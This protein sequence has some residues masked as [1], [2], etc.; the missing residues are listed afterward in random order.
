MT[1]SNLF[2]DLDNTLWAFSV[3]ADST[4]RE[5]YALNRLDRYF[6]SYDQFFAIYQKENLRLWGLYEKGEITK[7]ELNYRRFRH[8]L[9]VV[10]VGDLS[11]AD[12]YG[13]DFFRIIRTKKV[14][15]PHV[16]EVLQSLYKHYNL[17][18]LSNG[19][20]ELQC[21]KMHSGGIDTYFKLVILSDDIGIQKPDR[22]I[23]DYALEVT[24]STIDNSLMIGDNPHVDIEG[25]Y[26]S[27][28][29]QVY[30]DIGDGT[31]SISFKPTYVIKDMKE[32]MN[33]LVHKE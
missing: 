29:R 2:F 28:W 18:I 11:L 1:Y 12:R 32:L 24:G 6:K 8:P 30:Y 3:N 27:G 10:D 7:D 31:D 20:H 21:A 17:Y 23:F 25:A 26:L 19:F 16:L 15:M 14:L 22:R 9:Q 13:A 4:F 33:I 5:V